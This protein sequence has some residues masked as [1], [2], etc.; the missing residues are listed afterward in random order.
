M[1]NIL[2]AFVVSLGAVA[3]EKPLLQ[4]TYDEGLVPPHLYHRSSCQVFS[5][6]VVVT[7]IFNGVESA[8][9]HPI[10]FSRCALTRLGE[11]IQKA[12]EAKIAEK[13]APTDVP[14]DGYLA[15]LGDK[16]VVLKVSQSQT[17][18]EN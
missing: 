7:R 5:D 2:L 18:K 11:L 4:H 15:S 14:Y 10:A 12:S 16:E 17:S 6:K 9:T 8:E 1:K 13:E 3:A